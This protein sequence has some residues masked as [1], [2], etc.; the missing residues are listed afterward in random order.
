MSKIKVETELKHIKIPVDL[1]EEVEQKYPN[2]N[3]TQL[4]IIALR[5]YMGA[6]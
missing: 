4:V 1:L 3:F 6:R 5:D 2:V